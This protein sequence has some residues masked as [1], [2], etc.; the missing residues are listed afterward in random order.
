MS[1][2]I[3]IPNFAMTIL[4]FIL[5]ISAFT[6]RFEGTALESVESA[7]STSTAGDST[8][9][10][11]NTTAQVYIFTPN[12]STAVIEAE[13]VQVTAVVY[14]PGSSLENV[15]PIAAFSGAI[16]AAVILIILRQKRRSSGT[17]RYVQ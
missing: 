11:F 3:P 16:I 7:S 1:I 6:F 13:E 17:N 5:S 9:N 10:T 12:A 8:V 4:L 15:R 2:R 14:N